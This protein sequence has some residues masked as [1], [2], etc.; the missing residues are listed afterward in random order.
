MVSCAGAFPSKISLFFLSFFFFKDKSQIDR[1]Q[2][3]QGGMDK[4]NPRGEGDFPFRR[5]GVGEGGRWNVNPSM[6]HEVEW[7][8]EFK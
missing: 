1:G 6:K 3:T 8:R 2:H 7:G 4:S 5:E